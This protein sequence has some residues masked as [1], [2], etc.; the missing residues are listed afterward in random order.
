MDVTT[1]KKQ[2]IDFKASNKSKKK[3]IVIQSSSEEE[4]EDEEKE[5]DED[6][7]S[8]FTKKFNKYINKRRAFMGDMKD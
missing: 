1:T 7:M 6:E 3:K 4:E 5:Y 2:D 8:L